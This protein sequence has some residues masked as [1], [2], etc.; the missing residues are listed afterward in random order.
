VTVSHTVVVPV[1]VPATG[2][3][4]TVINVVVSARPQLLTT[5]YEMSAVPADTPVTMPVLLPTVATPVALLLQAPSVAVS[6]SVVVLSSQ[7][8]VVPVM[9]LAAG[10][11]RMVRLLPLSVPVSAGVELITR[12]R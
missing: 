8:V 6:L 12:M 5:E 1:M 11:A 4:L 3:G 9:L 2:S 7:T 10:L